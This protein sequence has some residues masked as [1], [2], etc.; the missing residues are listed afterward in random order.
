MIK[1]SVFRE[2]YI[3]VFE[4]KKMRKHALHEKENRIVRDVYLQAFTN[5]PGVRRHGYAANFV[6]ITMSFHICFPEN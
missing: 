3:Q 6:A 1:L 5:S 2:A 4:E